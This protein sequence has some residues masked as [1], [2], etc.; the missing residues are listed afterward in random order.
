MN[1]FIGILSWRS[2]LTLKNSLSS[3]QKN[4]LFE[5]A[6]EILIFFN[7]ISGKDEKIAKRYKLNYIGAAQNIGIGKAL[8]ALVTHSQCD[9]F[10]FLEE[11]WVLIE[12]PEI[13]RKRIKTAINL[14]EEGR[15]DVVRLRHRLK[16][17][18]PLYT[19]IFKGAEMKTPEYLFESI[20][21]ID[22]PENKFPQF[23]SKLSIND[24]EWFLS[25][26]HY[27]CYTNN[28]CIY[29]REFLTN[30]VLPFTFGEG[31]ALEEDLQPWWRGQDFKICQGSGLFE[32]KRLDRNNNRFFWVLPWLEIPGIW[33]RQAARSLG[34][35]RSHLERL[36]LL[37]PRDEVNAKED[38]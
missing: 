24:E 12:N 16:Y 1:I 2:P 36:G 27:A 37:T 20:H 11:D 32:H 8:K 9:Y 3:Y 25:S 33:V 10:L 6:D 15:A 7:E 13:T 38:K 31:L 23:I 17:G 22:H 30:N 28:P 35:R 29:R 26:A 34:L 21:W 19:I 5:C 14:L 18:D 4:G